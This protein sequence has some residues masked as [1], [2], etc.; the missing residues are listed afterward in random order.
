MFEIFLF[1]NNCVFRFL[2]I[3]ESPDT[4]NQ[5]EK[6]LD[7]LNLI[8]ILKKFSGYLNFI[9]EK[10]NS[11]NQPN[12]FDMNKKILCLNEL[13]SLFGTN[14]RLVPSTMY[15]LFNRDIHAALK[16]FDKV[17]NQNLLS[18]LNINSNGLTKLVSFFNKAQYVFGFKMFFYFLFNY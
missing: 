8:N 11:L 16:D 2:E 6:K 9:L 3:E 15:D 13:K 14:L 1:F 7:I 5:N 12:Y 18:K 4:D 17:L 10:Y